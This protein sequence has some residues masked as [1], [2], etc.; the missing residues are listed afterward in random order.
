MAIKTSLSLFF[1]F[2]KFKQMQLDENKYCGRDLNWI[3]QQ[4]ANQ[5]KT[6]KNFA[7]YLV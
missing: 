3:M 7:N 1:D 5:T 4:S 6:E 2:L